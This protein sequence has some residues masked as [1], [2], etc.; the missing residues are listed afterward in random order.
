[1]IMS[2]TKMR[3]TSLLTVAFIIIS[4]I[5]GNGGTSIK[6]SEPPKLHL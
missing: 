1:M 3:W 2:N 5:A 4:L 6:A